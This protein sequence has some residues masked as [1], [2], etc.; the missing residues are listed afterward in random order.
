MKFLG[1]FA[2][3]FWANLFAQ[4]P[5]FM[6]PISYD[7]AFQEAKKKE[8]Y[9]LV[10]LHADLCS[11]CIKMEEEVFP[12]AGVN[13]YYSKHFFSVQI[14]STSEDAISFKKKYP[15]SNAWP[16]FFIIDPSFPDKP[17]HQHTGA[18]DIQ[19]FIQFGK[20]SL[21]KKLPMMKKHFKET[22]PDKLTNQF[23]FN[24]IKMMAGSRNTLEE[25][26]DALTI[27]L[28]K[29]PQKEL[30]SSEGYKLLMLYTRDT[31]YAGFNFLFSN[32]DKYEAVLS[33]KDFQR[34]KRVIESRV[35]ELTTYYNWRI[36][37]EDQFNEF[38]DQAESYYKTDPDLFKVQSFDDLK[39]EIQQHLNKHITTYLTVVCFREACPENLL[40]QID[41]LSSTRDKHLGIWEI[42]L[43][44]HNLPEPNAH[45]VLKENIPLFLSD[46][47]SSLNNI[48]WSYVELRRSHP[49]DMTPD[50]LETALKWSQTAV[51]QD[52][53]WSNL[54]TLGW[55]QFYGRK[56]TLSKKTFRKV[57]RLAPPNAYKLSD[58]PEE[59]HRKLENFY[60]KIEI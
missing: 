31:T 29:V 51:K 16:E 21:S 49:E 58:I 54:D 28:S 53:S 5:S 46:V 11:H 36:W 59:F 34:L 52:E 25:G 39:F 60:S 43:A 24:Y 30:I 40:K 37:T 26:N 44:A 9:L 42:A 57:L 17:V 12:D 41:F 13:E 18:M 50:M 33:E 7:E 15:V 10:Y 8:C 6:S 4:T 20:D 23:L 47:P 56:R 48:A 55:L 1:F 32:R 19:S 3:F 2:L 22:P 45:K 35:I 27:Y 38:L 14:N